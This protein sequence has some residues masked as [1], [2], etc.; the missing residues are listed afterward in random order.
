MCK[1]PKTLSPPQGKAGPANEPSPFPPAANQ[2]YLRPMPRTLTL[3]K[4]V[5]ALYEGDSAAAHRFRY[6]LLVFDI[7]TI[8]FLIASSFLQSRGTEVLDAVIGVFL[9]ADIAARLWIA[10]ERLKTLFH[11]LFLIDLVVVFS[12]LAPIVGEGFAFLR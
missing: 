8:T 6:G 5:T 4:R 7:V 10:T 2:Y 9:L 11:P 1:A 12:L 3:K